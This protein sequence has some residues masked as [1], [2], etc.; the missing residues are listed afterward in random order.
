MIL[1]RLAA[2][3]ES[4]HFIFIGASVLFIAMLT[5]V[6]VISIRNAQHGG[7]D[8]EDVLVEDFPTLPE[9]FS[10]E[11][12]LGFDP[13]LEPQPQKDSPESVM[14]AQSTAAGLPDAEFYETLSNLRDAVEKQDIYRRRM[15]SLNY[16]HTAQVSYIRHSE[17]AMKAFDGRA[18]AA[19]EAEKS[20]EGG[21]KSGE[22]KKAHA[23]E[24]G[25]LGAFSQLTAGYK[26]TLERRRSHSRQ[27]ESAIEDLR[28]RIIANDMTIYNHKSEIGSYKKNAAVAPDEVERGDRLYEQSIRH[29]ALIPLLFSVNR[30]FIEIDRLQNAAMRTKARMTQCA[31]KSDEAEKA[32][33]EAQDVKKKEKLWKTAGAYRAR[34]TLYRC[35]QDAVVEQKADIIEHYRENKRAADAY[36]K[37][38]RFTL[39]E[40][41]SAEDKVT[42]QIACAHTRERMLDRQE[43]ARKRFEQAERVYNEHLK[44]SSKLEKTKGGG[45]LSYE[46]RVKQA[47]AELKEARAETAAADEDV[48]TELPAIN[49]LSLVQSGSGVLSKELLAA[50]A[51]TKKNYRDYIEDA[52]E[53]V[54]SYRKDKEIRSLESPEAYFERSGAAEQTEAEEPNAIGDAEEPADQYVLDQAAILQKLNELEEKARTELAPEPVRKRSRIVSADPENSPEVIQKVNKRVQ[55]V[56]RLRRS[57]KYID[58]PKESREFI[59]KLHRLTESFDGDESRNAAL[60]ELVRRT[61]KQA[62][63]LGAKQDGQE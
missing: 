16:L 59:A 10:F 34:E 11:R 14:A 3:L 17:E 22:A 42:G 28:S 49:P 19:R 21:R 15:D 50:A 25:L 37:T 13:Y 41:V 29:E 60:G 54:K 46:E 8:R 6:I 9:K 23:M 51:G 30:Y 56:M 45:K 52:A 62:R 12:K 1:S 63:Y 36:L 32:G 55:Q 31:K 53:S 33:D 47:L 61:Q 20:I 24:Q 4:G 35:L 39:A 7:E 44:H 43:S 26:N 58:T 5:V 38:E 40:I 48:E 2:A 18:F 57:L 27:I